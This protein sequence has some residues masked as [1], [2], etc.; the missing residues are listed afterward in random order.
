LS[1][2][3]GYI[4]T[5]PLRQVAVVRRAGLRPGTRGLAQP[6]LAPDGRRRSSRTVPVN[7]RYEGLG[8]P[9]CLVLREGRFE[10]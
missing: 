10:T 3:R 9:D 8:S 2:G 7:S 4:H 5:P 1:E 6:R